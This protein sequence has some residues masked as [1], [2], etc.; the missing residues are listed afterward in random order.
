MYY[1]IR[2]FIITI[3]GCVWQKIIVLTHLNIVTGQ[4]RK[5]ECVIR[6]TPYTKQNT[7]TDVFT[8]TKYENWNVIETNSWRRVRTIILLYYKSI[9][10][11]CS[12]YA[13]NAILIRIKHHYK[14]YN[15]LRYLNC[16][17]PIHYIII[18]VCIMAILQNLYDVHAPCV[19]WEH[20]KTTIIVISLYA[21]S[22]YITHRDRTKPLTGMPNNILIRDFGGNFVKTKFLTDRNSKR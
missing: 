13:H 12:F 7:Q 9:S 16:R 17:Y 3:V 6:I 18:V 20:F 5:N 8:E 11:S 2:L 21:A 15:A 19:Q 4:K 10:F 22:Y 14:Y 1:T